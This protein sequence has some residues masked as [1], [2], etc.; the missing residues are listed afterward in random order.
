[1]TAGFEPQILTSPTGPTHGPATSVLAMGAPGAL[2]ANVFWNVPERPGAAPGVVDATVEERLALTRRW[3]ITSAESWLQVT[4]RFIRAEH[5][6][7]QPA[8]IALDIRDAVL[9]QRTAAYLSIDD[10][11]TAVD[12][13]AQQHNWQHEAADTVMRLTVKIFHAE[14]QLATDGL[15]PAGRRVVTMFAYDLTHA[16][17]LIQAGA[18][19][20]YTD[21]QTVAQMLEALA[22]NASA[23]YTDWADFA[24]A[25]VL[26]HSALEGGYPRD[27]VY[28]SALATAQL[29]LSSPVSP[30]TNVPFP[31]RG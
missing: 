14:Q 23:I 17:Y 19:C 10:W 12:T 1:M 3:Q 24:A 13:H 28:R 31:G 8:E 11:L 21:P 29:L 30:W 22:H 7:N 4:D 9:E 2:G 5:I 15:L 27:E 6:R 18:R 26:G 20:G 16:A 25:F